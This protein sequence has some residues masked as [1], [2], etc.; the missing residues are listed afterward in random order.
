M[1]FVP[2]RQFL[3]KA[4]QQY[5]ASVTRAQKTLASVGEPAAKLTKELAERRDAAPIPDAAGKTP[6]D[7]AEA[8]KQLDGRRELIDEVYWKGRILQ[9]MQQGGTE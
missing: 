4:T 8:V 7:I 5:N 2:A 1:T 6:T 9:L 3:A